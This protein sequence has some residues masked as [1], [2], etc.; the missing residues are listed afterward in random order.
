MKVLAKF[1]EPKRE[2]KIRLGSYPYTYVRVVVM[3][4]LLLKKEDYHKL[5]KME[6]DEIA[7]FLEDTNYKSEINALAAKYSE[8]DLLEHALNKSLVNTLAKLK[9]ISPNELDLL[10]NAYLKRNDIFNIKTILRG[11]YVKAGEDEIGALLLPTG[12]LSYTQ[13]INLMKLATIE[14]VLKNAGMIPFDELKEAVES[15]KNENTLAM[16]EA[17]LD[18]SYYN[19]LL[20]FTK[21]LS[22]QEKL[23]R[24]FIEGEIEILNIM[25]ILRLKRENLDSNSIKKYLFFS[26]KKDKDSEL[27]KLLNAED[28]DELLKL[29][30]KKQYGA[31]IKDGL[32]ILNEK[33]TIID[34][35]IGLYKFLLKKSML[36]QHQ[37]PLSVDVILGYMFAKEIEVRNLKTIIKG[38]QLNMD[39]TFIE[40]QLV[41]A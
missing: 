23:F 35:E 16:I 24:E 33:G 15:Y 11:K 6:L 37:H 5:M 38:K 13:L 10:I 17:A 25:T 1:E 21:R 41:M 20:Q 19:E 8:A 7:R 36:L 18:R 4:A 2:G 40:N 26:G 29:L 22:R 3:R 31:I 30:E 28:L 34:L 32:K 14:D 12:S 9:R 27:M 39:E